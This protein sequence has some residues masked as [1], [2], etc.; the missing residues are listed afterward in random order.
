MQDDLYLQGHGSTDGWGLPSQGLVQDPAVPLAVEIDSVEVDAPAASAQHYA[1]AIA[2]PLEADHS[3]LALA[4][5]ERAIAQNVELTILVPQGGWYKDPM[6]GSRTSE[7]LFDQNDAVAAALLD[8][9]LQ[10][11]LARSEP[12]A[13]FRRIE[14]KAEEHEMRVVIPFQVSATGNLHSVTV[15]S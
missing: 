7:H 3:G 2:F 6:A 1:V 8:F 5:D 4:T 10:Q 12:R 11:A 14:A 9:N 15:S 13:S